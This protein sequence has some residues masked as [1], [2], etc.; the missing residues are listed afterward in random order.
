MEIFGHKK[1]DTSIPDNTRTNEKTSIPKKD[2]IEILNNAKS[3]ED[4]RKSRDDMRRDQDHT[5][6]R[7]HGYARIYHV[8][9]PLTTLTQQI[10]TLQTQIQDMQRGTVRRYLLQ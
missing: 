9:N 1:D 3:N 10:Q 4:T 8:D 2:D 5:R 6:V 7:T